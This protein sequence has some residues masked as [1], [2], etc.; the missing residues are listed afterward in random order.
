MERR[1]KGLQ[2]V[3]ENV[4]EAN[5]EGKLKTETGTRFGTGGFLHDLQQIKVLVGTVGAYGD[6]AG[7]VDGEVR[8]APAVDVVE[9]G[10][11][12]GGPVGVGDGRRGDRCR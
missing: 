11:K 1:V 6:V 5:N 12:R 8:I 10:G 4:G 7:G 9:G 2:P 3:L